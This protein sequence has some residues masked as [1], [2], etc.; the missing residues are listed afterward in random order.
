MFIY[1]YIYIYN[2]NLIINYHLNYFKITILKINKFIIHNKL[3][4][5]YC[6]KKFRPSI[7]N[8][9]SSYYIGRWI[10]VNVCQ[11]EVFVEIQLVRGT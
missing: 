2:C 10:Q 4:L 3:V 5:N 1:I 7:H 6:V 8:F 9:F 11:Q